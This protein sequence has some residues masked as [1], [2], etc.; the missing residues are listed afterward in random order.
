MSFQ[1]RFA[2]L[3]QLHRLARDEAGANLGKANEAI[4]R[5]D[6]QI[7]GLLAERTEMLHQASKAR[8]GTISIDSVLSHGRYEIQLQA[9]ATSLRETRSQLMN[10]AARRQQLLVAAEAEVKRFERLEEKESAMFVPSNSN[11]SKLRATK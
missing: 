9:E 10:E 4:R 1:F 6:E 5:I 2:T 11:E 8:I 3:L 7:E